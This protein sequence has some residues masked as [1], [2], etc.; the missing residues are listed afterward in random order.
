MRNLIASF[1]LATALFAYAPAMAAC[2]CDAGKADALA[3]KLL[4]DPAVSVADV[5]VRGMNMHNGQ[6]MLDIKNV[7]HGG[8]VAPNIRARFGGVQ[9]PTVPRY[10]QTMTVL[11]KAEPDGTYSIMDACSLAAV[12]KSSK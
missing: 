1:V 10:K 11:I 12:T 7:S 5:Y 8:L 9:C 3:Q 4:A 2:G 6:S